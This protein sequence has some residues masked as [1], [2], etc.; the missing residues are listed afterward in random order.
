MT[1]S[2]QPRVESQRSRL[3]LNT[4]IVSHNIFLAFHGSDRLL[5]YKYPVLDVLRHR[6]I[7]MEEAFRWHHFLPAHALSR[8]LPSWVNLH[9]PDL[10]QQSVD[11]CTCCAGQYEP[12]QFQSEMCCRY[13]A[14]VMIST[15]PQLYTLTA[16]WLIEPGLIAPDIPEI[17]ST[18]PQA[19]ATKAR[20]LKPF[21]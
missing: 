10:A 14:S 13:H 5:A 2:Y 20:R 9:R 11:H 8:M 7:I 3:V 21:T 12:V 1:C 6:L 18:T 4:L 17:T 15:Y 16:V 19:Q